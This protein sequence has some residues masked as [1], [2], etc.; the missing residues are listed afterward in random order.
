MDG[1]ED[2]YLDSST[3]VIPQSHEKRENRINH[4]NWFSSE[5]NYTKAKPASLN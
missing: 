2:Q 5:Q 1:R 4:L 3:L